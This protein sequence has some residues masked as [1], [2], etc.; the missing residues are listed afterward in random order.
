M[1]SMGML[2]HFVAELVPLFAQDALGHQPQNVRIVFLPFSCFK[3]LVSHPARTQLSLIIQL[4]YVSP[5]MPRVSAKHVIL[6]I[7]I[8][9]LPAMVGDLPTKEHAMRTHAQSTLTSLMQLV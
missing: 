1:V 9:A 3:P 4:L 5:A 2:Q 8:I 7:K 6:G